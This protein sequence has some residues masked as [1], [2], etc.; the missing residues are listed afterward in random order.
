MFDM[1][2]Q[3]K[4]LKDKKIDVNLQ[5][6]VDDISSR[7][8]GK[9]RSVGVAAKSF[10]SVMRSA[11]KFGGD[12][13]KKFII[14]DNCNSCGTCVRVCPVANIRIDDSVQYLHRCEWCLGCIHA[15]PRNAIHLKKEKSNARF[16]N[17]NVTLSEI[18][19]SNNQSSG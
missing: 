8:P 17:E 2:K 5:K 1:E 11:W 12:D 19:E 10:S 16:L 14:N 13:D 18:I 3:R 4:T 15:C 7:S 6:I 9:L